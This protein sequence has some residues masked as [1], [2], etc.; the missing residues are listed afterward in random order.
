MRRGSSAV[1]HDCQTFQ[2]SHLEGKGAKIISFKW[3]C[4]DSTFNCCN[5]RGFYSQ[6][7][8][9]SGRRGSS[10]VVHD[11]QTFQKSLLEWG[12]AEII[13]LKWENNSTF[14]C[15]K[16]WVF[17]QVGWHLGVEDAR[18]SQE[19]P[20]RPGEGGWKLFLWMRLLKFNVLRYCGHQF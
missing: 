8:S 9:T 5:S 19:S 11:C 18:L 20:L 17:H 6:V 15:Y 13:Y 1:V 14:N 12:G 7:V 16:S 4:Y 10:A 2:E 3:D